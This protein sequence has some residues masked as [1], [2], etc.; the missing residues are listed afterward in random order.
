MVMTHKSESMDDSG[1]LL[2]DYGISDGSEVVLI[3]NHEGNAVPPAPTMVAEFPGEPVT[4][5]AKK[6]KK[7]KKAKKKGKSAKDKAA[8]QKAEKERKEK[9]KAEQKAFADRSKA[10]KKAREQSKKH[11]QALLN[12]MSAGL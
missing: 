5:K 2:T 4:K 10:E 11:A 3:L 6:E 7:G 8:Q 12:K 9:E 1:A